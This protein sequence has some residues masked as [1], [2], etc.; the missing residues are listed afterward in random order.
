MKR[1]RRRSA[2]VSAG[3]E[4][5]FFLHS[6]LS[7][8]QGPPAPSALR[9]APQ[10]ITARPLGGACCLIKGNFMLNTQPPA[11]AVWV[12]RIKSSWKCHHRVICL[13]AKCKNKRSCHEGLRPDSFIGRLQQR[14]KPR[15][16]ARS[17]PPSVGGTGTEVTKPG[18]AFPDLP[19]APFPCSWPA[20]SSSST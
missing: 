19:L 10:A 16:P 4:R 12:S 15:S 17:L 6:P 1:K 13:T 9:A 2:E 5:E 14:R 18:A 7:G 11:L 3:S 8:A 20:P